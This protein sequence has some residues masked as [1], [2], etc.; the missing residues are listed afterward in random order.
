VNAAGQSAE[1]Q[2]PSV[3][4][5]LRTHA[6]GGPEGLACEPAAVPTPA[7]GD[8]LLRVAAAS[9]TPTELAW[10][11]TWVDRTGRDRTPVIPAHEVCGTVVGLG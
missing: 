7:I 9:F 11:S 10:P 4:R 3:M 1:P 5:A 2:R 8:V 6:R